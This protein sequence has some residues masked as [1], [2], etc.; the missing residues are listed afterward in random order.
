MFSYG[1]P[2]KSLNNYENLAEL[3]DKFELLDSTELQKQKIEALFTLFNRIISERR[4]KI[5]IKCPQD[6]ADIF[7]K[8]YILFLSNLF[9]ILYHKK[10]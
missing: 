6:V 2:L 3:R 9:I 7:L 1:I 4:E 10:G 8:L 5:A